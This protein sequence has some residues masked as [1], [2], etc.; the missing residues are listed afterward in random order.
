EGHLQRLRFREWALRRR[1]GSG[2]FQER[3]QSAPRQRLLYGSP[4]GSGRLPVLERH[5]RQKDERRQL[6][7]P[8]R[9]KLGS[10]DLEE[11]TLR[12]LLLGDQPQPQGAGVP[13]YGMDGDLGFSGPCAVG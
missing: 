13:R 7:Q 11:Q 6:L 4:S 9:R 1:S 5:Y 2:H 3:Q 8:V 10:A 12:L